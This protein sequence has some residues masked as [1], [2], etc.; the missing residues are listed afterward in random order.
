[1]KNPVIDD[2]GLHQGQVGA[3]WALATPHRVLLLD[4]PA[5]GTGDLSEKACRAIAG[6]V[7]AATG[8]RRVRLAALHHWLENQ[9]APCERCDGDGEVICN[10]GHHHK[11]PECDETREAFIVADIVGVPTQARLLRVTLADVDDQ[12]LLIGK[13]YGAGKGPGS[14]SPALV[15][16]GDGWTLI[17]MSCNPKDATVVR[18]EG[19]L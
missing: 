3:Q 18:F 9:A 5:G 4:R 10:L 6:W 14:D 8:E 7:A 16:H 12:E 11:C 17:L 1:M 19:W 13:T 15:I 2:E